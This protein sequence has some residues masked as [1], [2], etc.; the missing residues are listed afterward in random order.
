M[1]FLKDGHSSLSMSTQR[2]REGKRAKDEPTR[3]KQNKEEESF[4]F[5]T[6][7]LDRKSDF[8]N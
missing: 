7:G 2:G 1:Y 3:D 5:T 6:D 4:A 8:A